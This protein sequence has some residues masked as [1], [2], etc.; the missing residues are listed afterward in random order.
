MSNKAYKNVGMSKYRKDCTNIFDMDAIKYRYERGYSTY[1]LQNKRGVCDGY[2]SLTVALLR[3][4][5]IS[6]KYIPGYGYNNGSSIEGH[7]WTEAYVDNKWI[8]MDTT[9]DSKNKYENGKFSDKQAPGSAWF[10]VSDNEFSR[11]HMY[12]WSIYAIYILKNGLAAT[13]KP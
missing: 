7:A 9:W 1:V 10:N 2:A 5:G 6:A 13:K 3:A 4:A 12:L 8:N 11:T